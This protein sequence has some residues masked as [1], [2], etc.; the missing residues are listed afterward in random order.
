MLS[1]ATVAAD[2]EQVSVK[3]LVKT[4]GTTRALRGVSHSF[5]AGEITHLEGE[6]GSGKSTLLR[7]MALLGRPTSG[8][9]YFGDEPA[10][11]PQRFRAQIGYSGHEPMVYPDLSARENLDLFARFY[12]YRDKDER[13]KRLA[14]LEEF[15]G[16]GA[17]LGRPART[18]SRGQLQRLSLG[19]ALLHSPRLLLLDEPTNGLDRE[20]LERLGRILDQERARGAII[21]LVTHDERFASAVC[22]RRIR[23]HHGKILDADAAPGP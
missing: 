9:I 1:S 19:R 3:R 12:G 2:F 6:N 16:H 22:D 5:C 15:L 17:Y 18:Y 14:R 11:E 13:L 20:G 10:S 21:L 7:L 8:E 4:Y 23:I